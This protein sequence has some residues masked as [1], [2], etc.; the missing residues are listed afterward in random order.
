MIMSCG[1]VAFLITMAH[2]G[3]VIFLSGREH[4]KSYVSKITSWTNETLA[5]MPVTILVMIGSLW[6]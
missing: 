4:W 2:I 3:P 5:L 1:E 6:G